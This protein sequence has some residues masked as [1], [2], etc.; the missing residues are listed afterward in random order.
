MEGKVKTIDLRELDRLVLSGEVTIKYL[1]DIGI[2]PDKKGL[3]L[4]FKDTLGKEIIVT[5]PEQ[6]I[7]KIQ[8][9]D[10]LEIGINIQGLIYLLRVLGVK[11]KFYSILKEITDRYVIC[12]G[13]YE[14]N[15]LKIE[16]DKVMQIDKSTEKSERDS[17]NSC[18]TKALSKIIRLVLGIRT[19]ITIPKDVMKNIAS[20]K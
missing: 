16:T 4:Y 1:H 8:R 10:R 20:E 12:K 5:V 7:Y 14:I 9:K 19:S 6:F 3:M 18:L 2:T 11:G 15:D 13:V 17:I